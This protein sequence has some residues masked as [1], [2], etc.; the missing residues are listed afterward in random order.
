MPNCL[1]YLIIL[2]L[3]AVSTQVVAQSA[4]SISRPKKTSKKEMQDFFD[5]KTRT[6]VK[7]GAASK[8]YFTSPRRASRDKA[9]GDYF[10]QKRKRHSSSN[11]SSGNLSISRTQKNSGR[12]GDYFTKGSS[13]SKRRRSGGGDLF[14]RKKRKKQLRREPQEGLLPKKMY[15]Y[16]SKKRDKSTPI[17][18]K[19]DGEER[20]S[21]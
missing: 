12:M 20:D 10:T 4:M 15:W 1:K 2:L 7:N 6:N 21:Q 17:K 11:G 3:Y 14:V 8:D 16:K 13:S 5:F 18:R 19:S 9:M